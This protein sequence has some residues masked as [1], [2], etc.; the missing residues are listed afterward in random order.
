MA[1]SSPGAIPAAVATSMDPSL[2]RRQ[3]TSGLLLGRA[4]GCKPEGW[5][6]IACRLFLPTRSRFS[7]PLLA[8]PCPMRLDTAM[9]RFTEQPGPDKKGAKSSG[10][11]VRKGCRGQSLGRAFGCKEVWHASGLNAF[12]AKP[13]FQHS[14]Q[15]LCGC[16]EAPF[17]H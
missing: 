6:S 12:I 5:G 3:G 14:H 11:V 7:V 8:K 15:R 9:P 17:R 13:R 1:V 4:Q 10:P 16:R 2:A